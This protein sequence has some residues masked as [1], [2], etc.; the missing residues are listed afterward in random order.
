[1]NEYRP[2]I[3]V[4]IPVYNG[5]LYLAEALKSIF[6]Q[7]YD[8]LEII[9]VDDGSTDKTAEVAAGFGDTLHY[10]YQENCGPSAARNQ[11]L[12][13][14]QG[15]LVAFLDGDDLW[16]D[17]KIELQLKKF[18]NNPSVEIV[19]GKTQQIR[20]LESGN[21]NG[22]IPFL[23]PNLMLNLSSAMICKSAFD[24]AGLFDE[25]LLFCEDMDW[26]LRAREQDLSFIIHDD[27]TLY[28]RKHTQNITLQHQQLISYQL[29]VFKKSMDRRRYSRISSLKDWSYYYE[30]K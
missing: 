20:L 3:S 23:D 24:K 17:N 11:G 2:L 19:I 22:F 13:V 29:K 27:I 6:N 28:Y 7:N 8:P 30:T 16:S 10:I 26:F 4:I 14:A 18:N 1:M 25:T 12:R 5:E 9:I 21:G 15:S